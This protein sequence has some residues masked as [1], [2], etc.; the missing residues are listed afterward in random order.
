L[1]VVY[2]N[3]ERVLKQNFDQSRTYASQQFTYSLDDSNENDKIGF[4]IMEKYAGDLTTLRLNNLGLRDGDLLKYDIAKQMIV[5][6]NEFFKKGYYHTDLHEGNWFYK[7]EGE[8]YIVTI[9]DYGSEIKAGGNKIGVHKLSET[10]ES[11]NNEKTTSLKMLLI[12]LTNCSIITENE[13]FSFLD[14]EN[15]QVLLDK[16]INILNQKY[17]QYQYDDN[18]LEISASLLSLQSK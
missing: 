2:I 12:A 1:G 4:V 16:L 13:Y 10:P 5:Q 9:A 14:Y 15:Y 8:K 11:Q 6:L 18:F 3:N 17:Q 7:R